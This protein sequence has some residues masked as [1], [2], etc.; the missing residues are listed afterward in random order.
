MLH[1]KRKTQLAIICFVVL[2]QADC[3]PIQKASAE[4]N[5]RRVYLT[6]AD[7]KIEATVSMTMRPKPKKE[8]TYYWYNN[9]NIQHTQ[10][11][12]SGYL[13][14]GTYTEY[15]HPANTLNAKGR[16]SKGLKNGTWKTWYTNGKLKEQANWKKGRL[17]GKQYSFDTTGKVQRIDI[18]K[19]GAFA[20]TMVLNDT[21]KQ[22]SFIKT[23]VRKTTLFFKTLGIKMTRKAGK[24]ETL[25]TPPNKETVKP[26]ANAISK[27]DK[28]PART[29]VKKPGSK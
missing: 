1:R 9:T 20:D 26:T 22:G 14:D 28:Q 7:K 23:Q 4:S 19:R 6:P 29:P 10:G 24:Q 8:R 15:K 13:L 12:Y 16:Y 21:L 17:N 11:G 27:G 2:L 3:T 18:Y 25:P 5:H